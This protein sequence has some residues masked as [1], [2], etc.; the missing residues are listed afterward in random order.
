LVRQVTKQKETSNE[1]PNRRHLGLD[2]LRVRPLRS[3]SMIQALRAGLIGLALVAIGDNDRDRICAPGAAAH[4]RPSAPEWT[5][6]KRQALTEAGLNWSERNRYEL[7]HIIPRCLD[8]ANDPANLQLQ[9]WPQARVKD[10]L[11][12][13]TCRAYCAGKLTLEEARGRFRRD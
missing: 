9:L 3:T 11:E 12:A 10:R 5:R 13:E 2:D 8:G 4:G 7:D 6:L 1:P